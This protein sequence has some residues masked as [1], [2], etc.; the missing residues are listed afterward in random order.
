MNQSLFIAFGVYF[1]I[2][3]LIGL[4]AHRKDTSAEDFIVGSRSLNYWITALSAHA[5]DMSSW[6]FMAFPMAVFTQGL[7]AVWIALGLL[8]GMFINWHSI[9]PK[10]RVATERYNNFTLSGFL[11]SR[12]EDGSGV[13]RLLSASM[14][15]FF[16]THYLAAGLISLGFLFE[17]LFQ[18][19]Y[20]VGIC[21]A[22]CVMLAYTSFGGFVAVAWVDFFQGIFLLLMIIV[23]PSVAY[24]KIDGWAAI[25][26]CAQVRQLSLHLFPETK[27]QVLSTL[28]L[29]CAWG[30]GYF[31]MP[32]VLTKFM[33]IRRVEDIKKAKRLGMSWQLLSLLAATATGLVGI[34]FFC[35][36]LSNPELVFVDM[37]IACFPPLLSGFILCAVLAATISTMDSQILVVSAIITKDFYDT[38]FRHRHTGKELLFVSRLSIFAVAALAFCIALSKNATVYD[39][40]FY[41][42]TGLGCSFGPVMLMALHAPR[43]NRYGAIAGILTGGLF[44]FFYP[45]WASSELQAQVPAMIPGFALSMLVI[46]VV[47]CF[48]FGSG[49]QR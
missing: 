11:E 20:V 31:G 36:G 34:A 49:S 13:L 29:T 48:S 37:C 47:S 2:L 23:V 12:F 9:A 17:S 7:P 21:I 39:T 24:T 22:T 30:L 40:V 5:S 41:A 32:Q 1:S 18:M 26:K 10:L 15:L 35:E 38:L 16:V 43:S 27:A 42:W 45:Y 4:L 6:L 44:A 19:D 14:M 28:A 25:E 33:G 8:G 3:L 46:Y